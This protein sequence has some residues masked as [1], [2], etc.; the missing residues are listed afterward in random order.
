MGEGGG[1]K[2]GGRKKGGREEGGKEEEGGVREGMKGGSSVVEV[3]RR[4]ALR[5][6]NASA[7]INVLPFKFS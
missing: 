7:A 5:V 4:F 1:R 6:I 3:M 2:R